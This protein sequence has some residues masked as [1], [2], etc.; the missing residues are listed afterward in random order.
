MEILSK[1]NNFIYIVIFFI[2]CFCLY[3]GNN[4]SIFFTPPPVGTFYLITSTPANNAIVPL[5][6]NIFTFNFSSNLTSTKLEQLPFHLSYAAIVNENETIIEIPKLNYIFK[7]LP[8]DNRILSVTLPFNTLPEYTKFY[9]KID[10][11]KDTSGNIAENI[12]GS[13]E[14]SGLNIDNWNL[15]KTGQG[16]QCTSYTSPP[17][18]SCGGTSCENIDWISN[19]TDCSNISSYPDNPFSLQNPYGQNGFFETRDRWNLLPDKSNTNIPLENAR[20]F[21]GPKKSVIGT[22]NYT[23]TDLDTRLIWKVCAEGQRETYTPS[24]N[25]VGSSLDLTWGEALSTCSALN[26]LNL[27]RGYAGIKTWRLPFFRELETLIDYGATSEMPLINTDYF[28]GAEN[29]DFWTA[30]PL[31]ETPSIIRIVPFRF[32]PG[33]HISASTSL[34]RKKV[35]CVATNLFI[36][37]VNTRWINNGNNTVTLGKRMWQRYTAISKDPTVIPTPASLPIQMRWDE[38]LKYCSDL[39]LG[40]VSDWRLPNINE[41][42]S[43][44]VPNRKSPRILSNVFPDTRINKAEYYWSST[45][46]S[47]ANFALAYQFYDGLI[48]ANMKLINPSFVRCVRTIP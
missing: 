39:N 30:S 18:L 5:N 6:T 21:D 25:C 13:F 2:V 24:I 37:Q 29:E 8:T 10:N 14:T 16:N 4:F 9:W 46:A 7:I 28:N 12:S 17:V 11:I 20:S 41:L 1:K 19:T 33:L 36:Q 32:V 45:S 35:R 38:S 15:F 26:N 43:L 3:C 27:G 23:I 40:S 34:D 22:E 42:K 47:N 31:F 48:V 44:T